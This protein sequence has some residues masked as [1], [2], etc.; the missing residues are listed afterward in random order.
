M[1]RA[2]SSM[3]A[4]RCAGCGVVGPAKRAARKL[5]WRS[6]G[7]EQ[8]RSWYCPSCPLPAPPAPVPAAPALPAEESAR[9][10]EEPPADPFARLRWD[11]DHA[12]APPQEQPFSI[13]AAL[14]RMSSDNG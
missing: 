13:L 2:G 11:R 10:L 6:S 9:R 4:A 12:A 5:G 1:M 8:R 14:R 7:P 3:P